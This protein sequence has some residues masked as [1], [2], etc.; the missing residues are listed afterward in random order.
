[1]TEN[2][3][4]APRVVLNTFRGNYDSKES[5]Q[6]GDVVGVLTTQAYIGEPGDEEEVFTSFIG[7][8]VESQSTSEND[9]PCEIVLSTYDY[10]SNFTEAT[11]SSRGVFA[12]PVFKVGV[13]ASE[14]ERD[15]QIGTAEKGMIVF[16]DSTFINEAFTDLY[17]TKHNLETERINLK[18]AQLVYA[19]IVEIKH[20]SSILNIAKYG[21][22]FVL[23]GVLFVFIL[24]MLK[25]SF[26]QI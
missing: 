7:S 22:I 23:I 2:P 3:N 18:P 20:I 15:D 8:R 12:A 11:F 9:F 6:L 21:L 4:G 16:N 1:R 5:L 10:E 25:I 19:D 14:S 26:N 17:E 24:Q 13:F